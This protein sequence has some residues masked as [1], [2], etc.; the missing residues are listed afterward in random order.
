M[1]LSKWA[2]VG[3]NGLTGRGRAGALQSGETAIPALRSRAEDHRCAGRHPTYPRKNFERCRRYCRKCAETAG[4]R[5]GDGARARCNERAH[6]PR[7]QRAVNRSAPRSN[8]STAN[9]ERRRRHW[10]KNQSRHRGSPKMCAN[11]AARAQRAQ[12]E[13][14]GCVS[15][16]RGSTRGRRAKTQMKSDSSG[17][18]A[19]RKPGAGSR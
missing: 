5:A 8:G 17:L 16:W 11:L 12:N 4:T 18:Q 1:N 6:Q 2:V 9:F 3:L 15:N 7:T 19:P 10:M 13:K 14:P